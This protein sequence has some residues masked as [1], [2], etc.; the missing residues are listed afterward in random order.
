MGIRIQLVEARTPADLDSAFDTMV[1]QRIDGLI[2]L[3]SPMFNVEA[4]R[5]TVLAARHRLPAIYEWRTFVGAGGAI[6]YGAD[7]SDIYRRARRIAL[8]IRLT[9]TKML[10]RRDSRRFSPLGCQ[11]HPRRF[12]WTG[13]PPVSKA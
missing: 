3:V 8:R 12:H 11:I 6:S 5:I 13:S 9:V 10:D 1:Q 7:L 2:V 4:K